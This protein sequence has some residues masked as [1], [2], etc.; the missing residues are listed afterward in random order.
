MRLTSSRQ[1]EAA[2]AFAQAWKDRGDEKQDTQSFWT[3]L[4]S[5]VY[6]IESP[7]RF[8]QFEKR[9]KFG[10]TT[11]FIDGYIPAT[12]VLIEQ[13]GAKIDLSKKEEQSDGAPFTP[14]E[15]GKRYADWLPSSERPRWIVVCNF[16]LFEIHDLEKPNDEPICIALSDL[17]KAYGSLSFLTDLNEH[18]RKLYPPKLVCRSLRSALHATRAS[19]GPPCQRQGS[20]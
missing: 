17:P 7:A 10:G 15:Q 3:D 2:K 13:K 20:A 16:T 9:V 8:I 12:K 18:A 5:S 19:E 6:G 14:Y 4:L 11:K 1:R